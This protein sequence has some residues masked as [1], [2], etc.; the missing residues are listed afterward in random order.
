MFQV[1]CRPNK[2]FVPR[3]AYV[4]NA[5]EIKKAVNIPVI[6]VGRINDPDVAEAVISSG[7]ADIVSMGRASLADPE[8]PAKVERGREKELIRCIG[9]VQ[10]CVSEHVTGRYTRCLVNPITGMRDEYDLS[11]T[12]T[13][14]K[15]LVIGEDRVIAKK[16]DK[17]IE[18]SDVDMVVMAVGVKKELPDETIFEQYN[19][20]VV[21]VGDA[22]SVKNGFKNMLEAFECGL[23]I[24]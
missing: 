20:K 22:K 3:A 9:C 24:S 23:E 12:D 15:V 4:N 16:D 14:K 8:F 11:L 6:A 17:T 18:V 13:P 1:N 2:S 10:G 21:Y 7:K 19:G 5:A